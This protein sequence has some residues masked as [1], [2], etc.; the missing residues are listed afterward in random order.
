MS[1][2]IDYIR[3]HWHEVPEGIVI[4][5]GVEFAVIRH[6]E[7]VFTPAA[8]ADDF[9]RVSG[10]SYT[11]FTPEPLPEPVFE[12][13]TEPGTHIIASGDAF[14][15]GKFTDAVLALNTDGEWSGVTASG[16]YVSAEF[17]QITSWRPVSL[18][19]TETWDR[20]RVLDPEDERDRLDRDGDL[21]R[22][23]TQSKKVWGEELAIW[24]CR[25]GP[26]RF[27]DEETD[28]E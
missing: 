10:R 13:P 12:L 16:D 15:M 17:G 19:P 25:Y 20:L 11:R 5:D 9:Y 8:H 4:P 2:L 6:D 28:H 18:V 24:N 26:L 1:K 21:M 14:A 22:F 3:T 7:G 23:T 27:A